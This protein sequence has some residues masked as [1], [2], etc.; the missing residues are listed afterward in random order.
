MLYSHEL[1]CNTNH[2]QMHPMKI[3]TMYGFCSFF[4][5]HMV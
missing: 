2:S 3:L 4:H 1:Y 5:E